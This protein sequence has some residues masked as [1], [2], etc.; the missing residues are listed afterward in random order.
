MPQPG[1]APSFKKKFYE[2]F[3]RGAHNAGPIQAAQM[4]KADS[5]GI[6]C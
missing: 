2:D 3:D 5:E 4:L 1:A 6:V